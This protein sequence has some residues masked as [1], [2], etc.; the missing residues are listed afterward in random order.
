MDLDFSDNFIIKGKISIKD[1]EIVYKGD[2]D[3]E[4]CKKMLLDE[5][6]KL[7]ELQERLYADS[8]RCLLVLL[9]ALDAAGKDSLT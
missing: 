8:G 5:K 3:K 7:R 6:I 2:L 9:Q 1:L 4:A